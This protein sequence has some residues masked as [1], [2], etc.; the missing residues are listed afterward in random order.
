MLEK[1]FIESTEYVELHKDN[2]NTFSNTY[3]LLLQAIGA[4]L[5]T[6][7]KEYCEFSTTERKKYSRLRA[8]HFKQTV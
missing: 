6:V 7:F 2:F 5:D 3:A 4:E 1:R 8:I